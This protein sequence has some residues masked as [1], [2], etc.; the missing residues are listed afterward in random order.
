MELKPALQD[1]NDNAI[2]NLLIAIE[3][4]RMACDNLQKITKGNEEYDLLNGAASNVRRALENLRNAIANG[5]K[6]QIITNTKDAVNG[7]RAE[8]ENIA[9]ISPQIM[10]LVE[11]SKSLI[12]TGNADKSLLNQLNFIIDECEDV[13]SKRNGSPVFQMLDHLRKLDQLMVAL[14]DN[15]VTPEFAEAQFERVLPSLATLLKEQ[16]NSEH[17]AAVEILTAQA[18]NF[19]GSLNRNTNTAERAVIFQEQYPIFKQNLMKVADLSMEDT[20]EAILHNTTILHYQAQKMKEKLLTGDE[21]VLND[22]RNQ[23]RQRLERQI[24][25]AEMV[26]MKKDGEDE[27]RHQMDNSIM[28]LSLEYKNLAQK[29][30]TISTSSRESFFSTKQTCDDIMN[31]NKSILENNITPS[32]A[33]MKITDLNIE[34]EANVNEIHKISKTPRFSAAEIQPN[35]INI[36]ESLQQQELLAQIVKKD[37]TRDGKLIDK[38]I[39]NIAQSIQKVYTASADT[40][41]TND[42][43]S[44]NRLKKILDDTNIQSELL[45]AAVQK[46]LVD[47]IDHNSQKLYQQIPLLLHP[48]SL[49]D[50]DRQIEKTKFVK[51]FEKQLQLCKKVSYSCNNQLLKVPFIKLLVHGKKSLE[52]YE[53]TESPEI[54]DSIIMNLGT[55]NQHLHR[56]ANETVAENPNLEVNNLMDVANQIEQFSTTYLKDSQADDVTPK[57]R[58]SMVASSVASKMK[59]MSAGSALKNK[60]NFIESSK[61]IA[62]IVSD[63][64]AIAKEL[65]QLFPTAKQ[66]IKTEMLEMA[67]AAKNYSVVCILLL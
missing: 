38:S 27:L 59:V 2:S 48:S 5:D 65:L 39:A 50:S 24:L 23:T 62:Q 11:G 47:R 37:L 31:L 6:N 28:E 53:A 67:H 63:I 46:S 3:K 36:A 17:H 25:I 16:E 4:C 43:A 41:D 12:A 61:S 35:L 9:D 15:L 29:L 45:T 42:V 18:R 56:L 20:E 33:S 55:I 19:F 32:R 58:L 1:P 8:I 64:L 40:M 26:E 21:D 30:E 7:L 10:T 22:L 60:K 34:L 51:R 57:G 52:N 66:Q 14:Y 54:E 49:H 13:A 44:K